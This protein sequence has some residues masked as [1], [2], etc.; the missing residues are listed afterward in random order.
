MNGEPIAK[1]KKDTQR[2]VFARGAFLCASGHLASLWDI[3]GNRTGLGEE[4]QK[5]EHPC[6][7]WSRPDRDALPTPP[8]KGKTRLL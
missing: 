1:K 6:S 8:N 5:E 7:V 4:S 2:H 3:R